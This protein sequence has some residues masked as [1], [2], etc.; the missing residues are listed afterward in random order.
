MCQQ[1]VSPAYGESL[2]ESISKILSRKAEEFKERLDAARL[3]PLN[4]QAFLPSQISPDTVNAY[5]DAFQGANEAIDHV[6]SLISQRKSNLYS[7][8][9]ISDL[10]LD[11]SISR[12]NAAVDAINADIESLNA[13]IR[14]KDNL[15]TR[16][17]EINDQIAYVDARDAIFRY[18]A[19]ETKLHEARENLRK[20]REKQD[21]LRGERG[22]QEAKV[23]M[24]EIAVTSIN[25]FLSSVYFDAARF[26]LVPFGDVYRIESFGKPVAPKAI[27][28]GE[29]NIL[30]LCYFFSEGG[31]GKFEGLE[32]SDPQYL[33]IDD[34]VSSFDMENRVGICSLLRERISHVLRANVESRVTVMTHDAATV[35]ELEHILG[36]V[37]CDFDPSDNYG[38]CLL[39]LTEGAT[40]QYTRTRKNQY[41]ILLKTVYDYALSE[42]DL[43]EESYV[44]GN[45]MRRVLEGYSSFNFGMDIK[46][47]INKSE[48]VKKV[49]KEKGDNLTQKEKKQL[50]EEEKEFKSKRKEIQEKLIKF[51]TRI[52]VFMYLTDYREETLYDVITQLE[53]GLFKKVT[54][55][56]VSDFNLLVSLGVFNSALMND[57]VYKFRRYEDASLVYTGINKHEGEKV[58]LYDT[59]LSNYDYLYAKQQESMVAPDGSALGN[60]AKAEAP[61]PAVAVKPS[62]KPSASSVSR[63]TAKATML[64]EAPV[65]KDWVVGV[66]ESYN[67]RIADRRPKGGSLWV[68]GGGELDVV[69]NELAANGAQFTYKLEGGK[70][71]GFKAGWWLSGYPKKSEPKALEPEEPAITEDDLS[72]IE[73]GT[74]V[75]HKSFGYGEVVSIGS[76]RIAVRFDNDKKKKALRCF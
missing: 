11:T 72:K 51:A 33:V 66:L 73:E 25:R 69:M 52:P 58:G 34:P 41:S 63:S 71:T 20:R 35:A 54:G 3:L 6:N 28:T 53:P 22:A 19:A 14:D 5:E 56:D 40:L 38:Y 47:I 13:A 21:R 60:G 29:R 16:L 55:L 7:V 46:T 8:I 68:I 15:K 24:T 64:G 76:D 9:E 61:S 18:D 10:G 27:S 4:K 49:K 75:F 42:E 45:V 26:R 36:D 43:G 50:T 57:A 59:S 12:F 23:R 74:Q 31:R 2:V 70:A 39:E 32:D 44:I 37:K 67:V 62:V 65:K 1:E 30:A 17:R 48:A